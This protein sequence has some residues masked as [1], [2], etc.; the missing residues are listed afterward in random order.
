VVTKTIRKGELIT[1][2]NTTL[3]ADSKIAKL[4]ALQDQMIFGG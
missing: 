1:Y 2:D 3:P 4:R